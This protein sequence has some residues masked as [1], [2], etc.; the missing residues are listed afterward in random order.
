MLEGSL[1]RWSGTIV[2]LNREARERG[3][4]LGVYEV[5]GEDVFRGSRWELNRMGWDGW[6][7]YE[8]CDCG[9][10]SK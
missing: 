5:A 3:G 4:G 9:R 2:A 6:M 1:I 8:M 7:G 10:G